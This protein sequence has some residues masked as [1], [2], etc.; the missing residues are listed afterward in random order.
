MFCHTAQLK[1]MTNLN[2]D[3]ESFSQESSSLMTWKFTMSRL[4]VF[5]II[6]SSEEYLSNYS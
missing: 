1:E 2:N 4:S 5:L 6:A 3:A